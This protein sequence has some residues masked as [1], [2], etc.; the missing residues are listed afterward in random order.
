MSHEATNWIALTETATEL[1]APA[2][3]DG[4]VLY[5]LQEVQPQGR[6]FELGSTQVSR[7]FDAVVFF[8]DLEPGVNWGH[9]CRYL[10]M[11]VAGA[12]RE[13]LDAQW[14][15][16]LR[17]IPPS[18]RLVWKGVA[19]PAWAVVTQVPIEAR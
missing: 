14:P 13:A 18:L 16:F 5:V 15:P 11:D 9:R 8:V 17:S 19:A 1:V 2:E 6:A 10:V 3:R 4:A 7:P 12:N